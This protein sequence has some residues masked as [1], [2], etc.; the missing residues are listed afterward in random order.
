MVDFKGIVELTTNIKTQEY[1]QI[2]KLKNKLNR[3][4]ILIVLISIFFLLVGVLI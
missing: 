4:T 1:K 3:T 2:L